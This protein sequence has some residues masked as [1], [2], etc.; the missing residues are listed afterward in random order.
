M[1]GNCVFK[2]CFEDKKGVE[3][4]ILTFQERMFAKLLST[5]SWGFWCQLTWMTSKKTKEGVGFYH[6]E[7][8]RI[9]RSEPQWYMLNQTFS[10]C[11]SNVLM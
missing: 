5:K 1:E 8:R 6:I 3:W 10:P 4:G 2:F 9:K 7:I 11:L